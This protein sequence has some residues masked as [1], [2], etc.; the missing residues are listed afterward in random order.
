MVS[1]YEEDIDL[2][3]TTLPGGHLA[4]EHLTLWR[5]GPARAKWDSL[6]DQTVYLGFPF[7]QGPEPEFEID[8]FGRQEVR[9]LESFGIPDNDILQ[10]NP[11]TTPNG[12]IQSLY[13]DVSTE[14]GAAFLYGQGLHLFGRQEQFDADHGQ[15]QQ[16]GQY[17]GCPDEYFQ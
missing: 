11:Q 5:E 3:S 16:N 8:V 7:Q 2:T 1:T 10:L 13:G 12:D 15:H 4:G 6:G 17:A 9:A 14:H